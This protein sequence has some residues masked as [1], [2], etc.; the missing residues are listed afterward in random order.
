M[1]PFGGLLAPQLAMHWWHKGRKSCLPLLKYGGGMPTMLNL[2]LNNIIVVLNTS[3]YIIGVAWDCSA[4]VD[5]LD[6]CQVKFWMTKVGRHPEL[7][8]A[9]IILVVCYLDSHI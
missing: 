5:G 9:Y 1:D 3:S 4:V 7:Y 6:S 8:F 2:D